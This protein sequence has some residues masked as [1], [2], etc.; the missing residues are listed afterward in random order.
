MMEVTVDENV[1]VGDRLTT[2]RLLPPPCR[3]EVGS[4][5]LVPVCDTEDVESVTEHVEC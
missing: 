2:E 3:H 1:G 4:A 5:C